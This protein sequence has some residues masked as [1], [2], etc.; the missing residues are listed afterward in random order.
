MEISY[1]ISKFF[2]Y[3][4]WYDII[5][6]YDICSFAAADPAPAQRADANDGG[7]ERDADFDRPMDADEPE[8]RDYADQDPLSDMDMEEDAEILATLL[9]HIPSCMNADDIEQLLQDIPVQPPVV[10]PAWVRTVHW[11]EAIAA[12]DVV[13][14]DDGQPAGPAWL[15]YPYR[16]SH[17]IV[18][19]LPSKLASWIGQNFGQRLQIPPKRN[20]EW[21]AAGL[22]A[23]LENNLVP[24]HNGKG[25]LRTFGGIQWECELYSGRPK[26]RCYP[27]NMKGHR[28]RGKNCQVLHMI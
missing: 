11:Q 9:K 16:K 21:T 10:V 19:W 1:I 5:L 4:I 28:F 12:G 23:I 27:F 22:N 14:A 8:E 2:W 24:S 13:C 25:Q 15:E 7:H 17:P 6:V 18:R 3:D 20:L 26:A